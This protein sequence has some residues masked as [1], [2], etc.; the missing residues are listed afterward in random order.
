MSS[1]EMIAVKIKHYDSRTADKAH[2]RWPECARPE[3][4]ATTRVKGAQVI[5]YTDSR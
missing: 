2:P 1:I 5:L 3:I 4:T